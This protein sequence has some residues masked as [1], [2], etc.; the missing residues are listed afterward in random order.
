MRG[1][2]FLRLGWLSFLVYS[3]SSGI[4]FLVVLICFRLGFSFFICF[5][6]GVFFFLVSFRFWCG[7]VLSRFY[8][9]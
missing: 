2:G 8:V 1:G 5:G 7:V 4:V 6:A 9:R 3:F